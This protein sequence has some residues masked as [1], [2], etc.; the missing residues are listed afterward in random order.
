MSEEAVVLVHGIW[1]NGLDMGILRRRLARAGFDPVQFRYPSVRN[2]PAINA[3][4]LNALARGLDAQTV[5]FVGHSLGGIVIRH[6]FSEYPDQRPGRVVTMGTPHRFSAAAE[7]LSRSLPG[8]LLLGESIK[9]GLLGNA[10]PW[11]RAREL[12]SIAGTLRLG[13]GMVVPGVPSPNDGTV[14]V[15]ETRLPEMRDH[16]TL[17]VSHFGLLL[18]ARAANQTAYFLRHGCF[19]TA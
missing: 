16:L 6:L 12:G 7:R 8:R 15:E 10:P 19:Q 13:F 17:P 18:S 14:A 2:A 4:D 5:H 3:M 1:M 11:P 9:R